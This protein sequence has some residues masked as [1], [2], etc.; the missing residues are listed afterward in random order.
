MQKVM[1]VADIATELCQFCREKSIKEQ[2][3]LVMIE[4]QF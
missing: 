4:Q 1:T 3:N 2:K